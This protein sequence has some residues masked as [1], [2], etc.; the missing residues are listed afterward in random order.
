MTPTTPRYHFE[1]FT[2]DLELEIDGPTVTEADI[3]DFASKYDPQSFHVDPVRA[4]AS[5]YGGLIASGWHTASLCMRLIYDAY[6][7]EAASLGSP[8]IHDLRW[9]IPVRPGDRL[10]MKMTVESARA[11][12]SKPDRG[13]VLHRWQVFIQNGEL[14]MEMRGYGMFLKRSPTPRDSPRRG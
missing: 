14:V 5:M 10:S 2:P 4:K 1:D 7:S 9:I 3:I 8:G 6:L 11:S 13:T 12:A